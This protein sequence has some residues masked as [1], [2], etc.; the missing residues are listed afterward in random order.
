[1]YYDFYTED[2]IV[3]FITKSQLFNDFIFSHKLSDKISRER[4]REKINTY[5]SNFSTPYDI[6]QSVNPIV[7]NSVSNLPFERLCYL[8]LA[9]ILNL[10]DTKLEILAKKRLSFKQ[11]KK[12]LNQMLE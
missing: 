6:L 8:I 7:R 9:D 1:M 2:Q 12:L 5:N 10:P 11:A 3:I 4:L